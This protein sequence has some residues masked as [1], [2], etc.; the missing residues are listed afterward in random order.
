MSNVKKPSGKKLAFK[1]EAK[2]ATTAEIVIYEQ[3]G[4]SF[5][6]DGV[7]AKSFSEELKNLGPSIK[8]ID[9]RLNS[10]GGDVFDGIT[11]YNRLKQH[12]ANVTVHIDGLA[13]SIASIIALAGDEI[14]MGEGAL[15]MVHLP[16]TMAMGDRNDLDNTVQ[17]LMDIEEQ[18]LTIYAK[19]SGMD[20]VEIRK[21]LEEETWLDS[22]QTVE[23][24]FADKKSEDVVAI[25]A[26]AMDKRWINKSPKKYNSTTSVVKAE[27]IKL[28][29]KIEEKLA[30]K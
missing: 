13:A 3:I 5:W 17:R 21:M 25:A 1:V 4:Y 14:I 19:R 16:W 2:T 20:R 24:G 8:Q 12:S 7:T 29:K 26:S 30:L 10:P 23:M 22:D 6:E 9:L 27:A 28:Q 11:I 18:M 15:Y